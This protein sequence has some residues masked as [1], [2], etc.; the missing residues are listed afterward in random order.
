[1][2]TNRLLFTTAIVSAFIGF[3]LTGSGCGDDPTPA[4]FVGGSGGTGGDNEGGAGGSPDTCTADADCVSGEVCEQGACIPAH[5]VNKELDGDESDV[6]CG[7][8]CFSCDNGL[9]CNDA[10]DC[11]TLFCDKASSAGGA[12]GTGG[13]GGAGGSTEDGPGVCAACTGHEDCEGAEG[14]YCDAGSCVVQKDLGVACAEHEECADGFCPTDDGVCCNANCTDTCEA[15]TADKTGGED[16]T[17]AP[18]MMGE[19]P[20]TECTDQGVESCGANGMG[21]NGSATAPGCVLYASG[22]VCASSACLVDETSP[23][24]ACDGAGTCTADTPT[25]CAPYACDDAELACQTTCD[26]HADCDAN[27]YCNTTNN[28]CVPKKNNGDGCTVGDE[29]TS[30]ACPGQD[31]IC[32][33]VACDGICEACLGSKTGGTN[34]TCDFIPSGDIDNECP[35]ITTCNGSGACTL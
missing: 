18:V 31:G 24:W 6:D 16:G 11:Q 14:T 32:C 13:A 2:R 21:C 35:T 30:G 22:E 1:M 20:D 15:C 3:G 25:S 12:G 28:T 9:I 4:T 29:C 23:S 17:C 5:C 10:T 8:S 33:D 27:H 7:G 26:D 19:D 34:G